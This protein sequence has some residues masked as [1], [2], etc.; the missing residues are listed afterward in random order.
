[1]ETV[2]ASLLSALIAAAPGLLALI[3]GKAS[4]EE[5]RALA[6][7]SLGR[8]RLIDVDGIIAA[9]RRPAPEA[10]PVSP[11]DPAALEAQARLPGVSLEMQGALLRAAKLV[12]WRGGAP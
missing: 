11:A 6:L 9:H 3:T 5:A 4:D 10:P 1:M 12:R 2:V 8:L 7:E